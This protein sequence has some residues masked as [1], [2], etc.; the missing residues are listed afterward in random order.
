MSTSEV[1]VMRD[2]VAGVE[3][4]EFGM[5]NCRLSI[6]S[7]QISNSRSRRGDIIKD[8]LVSDRPRPGQILKLHLGRRASRTDHVLLVGMS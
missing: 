6:N 3:I 4:Q 2:I 1:K 5:H 7:F 8:S